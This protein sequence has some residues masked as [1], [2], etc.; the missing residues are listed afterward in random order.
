MW[1]LS[2]LGKPGGGAALYTRA[3]LCLVAVGRNRAV[4]SS[5]PMHSANLLSA[6]VVPPSPELRRERF[7]S[8]NSLLV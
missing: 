5:L 3:A 1:E 2:R 7:Q 6:I 8:L 4:N